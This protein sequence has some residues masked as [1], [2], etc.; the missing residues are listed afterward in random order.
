MDAPTYTSLMPPAVQAM[1]KA[2]ERLRAASQW[3]W[4]LDWRT[5]LY[6]A[7]EVLPAKL[8]V[9]LAR[10]VA[11]S[12][13]LIRIAA[14]L[15]A[16]ADGLREL[17]PN[18]PPS[19]TSRIT[20][21][22]AGKHRI[23]TGDPA[24][25]RA[26]V[27]A[28]HWVVFDSRRDTSTTVRVNGTKLVVG[29]R[30]WIVTAA[31][32]MP[33]ATNLP[34]SLDG[35]NHLVRS[36]VE[37]APTA[38]IV[39]HADGPARWS[40]LDGRGGSWFPDGALP[41]WDSQFVPFFHG[42]GLLVRVP[43]VP[44]T[45]SV[46]RGVECEAKTLSIR[47]KAADQVEIE[48]SPTRRMDPAANGWYGADLHVHPH[49]S[50]DLVV[51]PDDVAAMQLGE[52]LHVLSVLAAN[53][54]TTRVYDREAFESLL[55]QDLPWGNSRTVARYGL[56]YRNDLLGHFHAL[57]PSGTPSRYHTGHVPEE[58]EED[59][60][61]N[62]EACAEQRRLGA[63]VGYAHPVWAAFAEDGS[64]DTVF[65]PSFKG[66]RSVEARELV[67]DAALGLVDSLDLLHYGNWDATVQLYHH[68]LGCGIRIAASVGTD[69]FLSI[70]HG[71][72]SDPPGW[73]RMYAHL[74]DVPLSAD[75]YKAAIRAGRT[76]A[77]NGPW[78]TLSVDGQPIGEVLHRRVDD[79]LDIEATC[80]GPGVTGVELIGADGRID[81]ARGAGAATLRSGIRV[82]SATWIAARAIG[83]KHPSIMRGPATA[84][85]SPVYV[86]VDGQRVARPVDGA[87]CLDW[88]DRLEGLIREHGRYRDPDHRREIL[89]LVERARA[90]YRP[91]AAAAP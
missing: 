75:A 80:S 72:N 31:V 86:D 21:A 3:D 35:A 51:T 7:D 42:N 76:L 2:Y 39:L 26:E 8:P 83:Q 47:P 40:V 87:W 56:E 78:I 41:K 59:W 68:L 32:L 71:L 69:V 61:A 89:D 44:L 67:V 5:D 16:E 85:T 17:F 24:W 55:G 37:R 30:A 11:G 4:G 73:A 43:A 91:I 22:E 77:T 46:T 57:A 36:V 74:G 70:S 52:G 79:R 58:G 23:L 60:P 34:V 84:H 64:P 28:L 25:A 19:G 12:P 53:L 38:S 18:A 9:P 29:P 15:L 48:L 14:G 54:Y 65:Q 62:A 1:L 49:Y 45:V 81:M 13:I 20:L 66:V 27:P 10:H 50:G 88:L 6:A 63:T 82:T 90:F 33:H